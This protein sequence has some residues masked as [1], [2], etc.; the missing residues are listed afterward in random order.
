MPNTYKYVPGELYDPYGSFDPC[1]PYEVSQRQR[2]VDLFNIRQAISFF[3]RPDLTV[4]NLGLNVIPG[5][6]PFFDRPAREFEQSIVN[7]LT[8]HIT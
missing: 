4:A 3:N 2:I 7:E 6:E 8:A 1:R 5:S